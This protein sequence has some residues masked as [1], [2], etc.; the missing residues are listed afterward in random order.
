MKYNLE[1]SNDIYIVN[2][3]KNHKT[4]KSF[5]FVGKDAKVTNTSDDHDEIVKEHIFYDDNI[6]TVL[7][8]ISARKLLHGLCK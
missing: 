4:K 3:W 7:N 8:K 1:F 6:N 5:Y 2:F